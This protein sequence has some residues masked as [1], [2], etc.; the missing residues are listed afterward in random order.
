MPKSL[1]QSIILNLINFISNN[2]VEKNC[3]AGIFIQQNGSG[4]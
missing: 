4:K 1:N 3:Y 2:E